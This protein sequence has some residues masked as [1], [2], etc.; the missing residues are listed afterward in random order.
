MQIR[1]LT[2][3]DEDVM[4]R[5]FTEAFGAFDPPEPPVPLIVAGKRWVYYEGGLK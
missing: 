5:Q 2:E 4:R 1:R 3:A